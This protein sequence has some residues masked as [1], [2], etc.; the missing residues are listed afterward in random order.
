MIHT[1]LCFESELHSGRPCS[2]PL[3]LLVIQFLRMEPFQASQGHRAR[4]QKVPPDQVSRRPG[5]TV[6]SLPSIDSY[7][8]LLLSCSFLS[9][10]HQ[11]KFPE[12]LTILVVLLPSFPPSNPLF[13]VLLYTRFLSNSFFN[14]VALAWWGLHS[15]RLHIFFPA[16][17]APATL[18]FRPNP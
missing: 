18:V 10:N 1:L 5:G 13:S 2:A 12:S 16:I 11:P 3:C 7:F 15:I 4:N 8:V 6:V 17:T 14:S 9:S